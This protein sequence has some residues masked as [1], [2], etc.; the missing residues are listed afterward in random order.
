MLSLK[1]AFAHSLTQESGAIWMPGTGPL[2][3]GKGDTNLCFLLKVSQPIL[4]SAG[5][6]P[7]QILMLTHL[8]SQEVPPHIQ[9]GQL[10]SSRC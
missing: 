1:C 4:L 6:L 5:F 3:G 9:G 10:L 2:E 8:S 7:R